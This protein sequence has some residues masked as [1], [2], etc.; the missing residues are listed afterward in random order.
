M[1]QLTENLNIDKIWKKLTFLLF[2]GFLWAYSITPIQDMGTLLIAGL[3]L[4][5]STGSYIT[6]V[7]S[8]EIIIDER[9]IRH[10]EMSLE[11]FYIPLYNLLTS[12]N[13]NTT[14]TYQEKINEIDSYIHLAEPHARCQFRTYQKTNWFHNELL[15]QVKDDIEA[16][17]KEYND[18]IK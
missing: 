16:H 2:I 13:E 5:I 3:A 1:K 18:L 14:I 7:Q 11:K 15:K 10:I 9:R 17:Q 8:R 4:V 6:S 12:S